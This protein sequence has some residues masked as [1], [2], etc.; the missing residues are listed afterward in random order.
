MSCLCA[1]R[2]ASAREL[3]AAKAEAAAHASAHDF[4]LRTIYGKPM[5]LKEVIG[6]K[7]ALIVNTASQCGLTP[8]FEGLQALH[9][10]HSPAGFTVLGVPCNQ[11]FA[12]EKGDERSI[13]DG[14]CKRFKVSF[15]MASKVDVNGEKADPLYRWLKATAPTASKPGGGE[16][17]LA[18]LLSAIAPLSAWMAGTK[19]SEPG[20][21]E[22]NFAKFLVDRDGK[23]VRRFLP[24]TKP[25][26]IEADIVAA[27]A[28]AR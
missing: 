5:P 19:L 24:D 14:V 15:P 4:A 17:R 2:N 22:H 8:Q 18:G 12:Q 27:L 10:K 9:D 3:E 13:A 6:G 25:E 11:F 21:I 20:R 7:V 1:S 23:V 16:A 28:A 26:R